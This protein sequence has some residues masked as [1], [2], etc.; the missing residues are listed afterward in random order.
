MIP[1]K[2][3]MKGVQPMKDKIA[4]LGIDLTEQEINLIEIAL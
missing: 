2:H 3:S 4:A 1:K